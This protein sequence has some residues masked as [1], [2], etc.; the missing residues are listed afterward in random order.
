LHPEF[1]GVGLKKNF[2]PFQV[3]A[4]WK[5]IKQAF[6]SKAQFRQGPV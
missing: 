6:F 5:F 4:C 2:S 3:K 1:K